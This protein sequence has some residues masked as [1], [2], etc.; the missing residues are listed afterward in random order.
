MAYGI[1]FFP[2]F[3]FCDNCSKCNFVFGDLIEKMVVMI[4]NNT[5]CSICL[6]FLVSVQVCTWF[7]YGCIMS[8]VWS[9]WSVNAF[10]DWLTNS[11]RTIA[12]SLV[13]SLIWCLHSLLFRLLEFIALIWSIL[14]IFSYS[15]HWC[16]YWLTLVIFSNP[17]NFCDTSVIL[18]LA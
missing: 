7:Y 13:I 18:D 1:F 3:L 8:N 6:L 10:V 14:S 4:L 15:L 16:L 17:R 9:G 12:C 2:L 5:A 11:F